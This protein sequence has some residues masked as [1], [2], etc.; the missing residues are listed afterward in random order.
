MK[1][2]S[3]KLVFTSLLLSVGISF[4]VPELTNTEATNIDT[5]AE[6]NAWKS[7]LEM[8]GE[9]KSGNFTAE[10]QTAY[11]ADATLTVTDPTPA[12]GKG[13][14]VFVNAGTA[15]VGG[16]AYATAGTII[17]RFYEGGAWVSRAFTPDNAVSITGGSITGITDLAVA[18]GG[19]GASD[20]ATA[21]ENLGLG[22][23]DSPTFAGATI[24]GD[25]T[26]DTSTLKVD[27]ANNRVGVNTNAPTSELTVNGSISFFAN[28]GTWDGANFGGVQSFNGG[29]TVI[30]SADFIL[31]PDNMTSTPGL[32]LYDESSGGGAIL[33]I[34]RNPTNFL[35]AVIPDLDSGSA[36]FVMTAGTQT[37][38]GDKTFSGSVK[39]TA[40]TDISDPTSIP[41]V[42]AV[43]D[44]MAEGRVD[45]EYFVKDYGT[46]AVGGTGQVYASNAMGSGVYMRTNTTTGSWA[47]WTTRG[48]SS[49]DNSLARVKSGLDTRWINWSEK[50][51]I[52]VTVAETNGWDANSKCFVFLGENAPAV[53]NA[54]PTSKGVGFSIE[55]LSGPS[56]FVYLWTH[57]GTTL[58]KDL[59]GAVNTRIKLVLRAYLDGAGNC[60]G[61]FLFA[62]N[63]LSTTVSTAPTGS[64]AS[65]SVAWRAV[66]DNTTGTADIFFRV[67]KAVH[68]YPY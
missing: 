34:N 43:I 58:H 37:I 62:G 39:G 64:P 17:R 44:M 45:E 65:G 63:T 54:E 3:M 31:Y 28:S 23:T 2:H 49:G 35:T 22:I 11:V 36:E 6:R 27:S 59:I 41:N 56:R 57:D 21:A 19:T 16:T 38:G 15:T 7:Q 68:A 9:I 32:V 13:F 18:D 66:A 33:D 1:P 42:N 46:S 26:V 48:A 40:T 67:Y 30:K 14:S 51:I 12:E 5:E 52:S 61:K 55:G 50:Q 29:S 53:T 25:L 4:A 8:L 20:A 24:T 10:N 60:T 47:C